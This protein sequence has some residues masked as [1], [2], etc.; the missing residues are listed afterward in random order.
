MRL[1]LHAACLAIAMHMFIPNPA[2]ASS[3]AQKIVTEAISEEQKSQKT[4]SAWQQEKPQVIAEIKQ[5]QAELEWFTFQQE[6]YSNYVATIEK[7]IAEMERQQ[8]ELDNIANTIDPLLQATVQRITAF[9]E[10]DIPFLPEERKNRITN[11]KKALSDPHTTQAEQLR[12]VLE[13]LDVETGYGSDLEIT[14]EEV[15]LNNRPIHA[16]ALRAGRLGYYCITPDNKEIGIWSIAD[17]QFVSVDGEEAKAILHLLSLGKRKQIIEVT[18]VPVS[19]SVLSE[20][21]SNQL[22]IRTTAHKDQ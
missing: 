6:K 17:Q 3:K 22:E 11:I 16:T 1:I 4:I 18:P 14:D 10:K 7:N 19:A 8:Q 9:V 21:P 2:F 13:T 20:V 5:T 12:R 15:V